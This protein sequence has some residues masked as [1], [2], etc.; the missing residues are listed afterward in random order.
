MPTADT[1]L[2]PGSS[3]PCLQVVGAVGRAGGPTHPR[4]NFWMQVTE[5]SSS[6]IQKTER[7]GGGS[8]AEPQ[9]GLCRSSG[10]P[11]R[12]LLW[13]SPVLSRDTQSQPCG[14]ACVRGSQ[15]RHGPSAAMWVK[16]RWHCWENRLHRP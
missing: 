2:S 15:H 14:V 3:E 4:I 9:R 7:T 1:Q 12:A 6:F 16:G 11:D 10:P 13:V 8:V 5:T